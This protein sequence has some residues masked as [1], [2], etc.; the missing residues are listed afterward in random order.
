MPARLFK[1]WFWHSAPPELGTTTKLQFCNVAYNF[2]YVS[3]TRFYRIKLIYDG[4]LC[5]G[6]SNAILPTSH[7]I[8]WD[9]SMYKK[10]PK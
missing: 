9:R 7:I 10:Q 1:Q 2:L 3:S 4:V 6:F 5:T 8:L